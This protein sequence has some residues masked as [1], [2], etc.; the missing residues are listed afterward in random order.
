MGKALKKRV[1]KMNSAKKQ[2]KIKPKTAYKGGFCPLRAIFLLS[3]DALP[4]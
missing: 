3:L 2:P 1:K 4:P